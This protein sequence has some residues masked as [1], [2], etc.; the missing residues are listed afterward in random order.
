MATTFATNAGETM[1]K[2]F[3]SD[4]EM[5]NWHTANNRLCVACQKT[6]SMENKIFC[7][8]CQ[9][10]WREARART[11][12]SSF[13]FTGQRLE[14]HSQIGTCGECERETVPD[15]YLCPVCRGKL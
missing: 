5:R 1:L 14:Y 3:V 8:T 13:A 15:D 12:I 6:V 11:G 9:A 4:N 10:E 2:K 7:R